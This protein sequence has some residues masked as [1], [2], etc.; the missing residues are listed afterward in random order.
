M[1]ITYGLHDDVPFQF[2]GAWDTLFQK[3]QVHL[4][5]LNHGMRL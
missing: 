1:E 3:T 2:S 5:H 4:R